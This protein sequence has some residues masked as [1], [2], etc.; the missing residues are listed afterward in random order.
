MGRASST[1]TKI[2][3]R[4]GLWP[5]ARAWTP[6]TKTKIDTRLGLQQ[7]ARPRP[8]STMTQSAHVGKGFLYGPLSSHLG[9]PAIGTCEFVLGR[10]DHCL[11]LSA[12]H[13]L[14]LGVDKM[15]RVGDV[16]KRHQHAAVEL[17]EAHEV[18]QVRVQV[19]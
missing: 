6:S 19:P 8:L 2:D 12:V 11:D 17:G 4:L 14:E 5:C 10:L 9:L 3:R 7:R 15:R 13:W 1:V 16:F 18:V